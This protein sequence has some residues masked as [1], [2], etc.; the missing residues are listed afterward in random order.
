M[1]GANWV[2]CGTAPSRQMVKDSTLR[3]GRDGSHPYDHRLYVI[4]YII[5][6]CSI[7]SYT[8]FILLCI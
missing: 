7:I 3:L 5:I 8:S 4:Y 1:E 2:T 6:L